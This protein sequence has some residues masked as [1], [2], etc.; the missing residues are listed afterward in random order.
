MFVSTGPAHSHWFRPAGTTG[1]AAELRRLGIPVAL[2]VYASEQGV[3][4]AQLQDGVT[5]ALG[6]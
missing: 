2:R 5:W 4:R 6:G 1:F 3:W